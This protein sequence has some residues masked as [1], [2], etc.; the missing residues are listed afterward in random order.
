MLLD[1]G[2]SNKRFIKILLVVIVIYCVIFQWYNV[3]ERPI[4]NILFAI[5]G[6]IGDFGLAII[7]LTILVRLALWPL[8]SKQFKQQKKMQAI[9]PELAEIKR[10]TK[11]NKM[12]EAT[13]MQELY[14]EKEINPGGSMLTLLIQMPIFIAIFQI[15]RIFS[16]NIGEITNIT[17]G[18]LSGLPRVAETL[19]NPD[20]FS[21]QLFGI[22]DLTHIATQDWTIMLLAVLAAVFQYLQTRQTMPHNKNKQN[23]IM[24]IFRDAAKGK[25]MS[26]AEVM[27]QSMGSMTKFFPILTF[28]I[29]IN[30]PGALVLY[31]A[32]TS[33]AAILQQKLILNGITEELEEMADRKGL[34][35]I[36]EAEIVQD[37]TK[38]N[39]KTGTKVRRVT[40]PEKP[41]PS[42][43]K[44]R[45]K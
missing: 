28:V 17:Y 18:F 14:K 39:K 27:Q 36:K 20:T 22:V 9:Q 35:N 19:G 45:K 30:F 16:S 3:I 40:A 8:V 26:Q 2:K 41:K 1:M 38:I 5:Y 44:G 33:L 24:S 4:F 6:L 32:T 15:I 34:K 43:K 37:N 11:G 13:M 31:Y 42:D 10:K 12:L 21:P 25:E 7:A 29:A 23:G